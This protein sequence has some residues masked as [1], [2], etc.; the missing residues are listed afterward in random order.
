[1]ALEK[2]SDIFGL[3]RK[4]KK[5]EKETPS[6]IRFKD[7]LTVRILNPVLNYFQETFD[8]FSCLFLVLDETQEHIQVFLVV[9]DSDN[10]NYDLFPVQDTIFKWVVKQKKML[11]LPNLTP[12]FSGIHY[13]KR[14]EDIRSL[15][16]CPV[17]VDD[18]VH[19]VICVD[20]LHGGGMPSDFLDLIELLSENIS[21][22]LER[23]IETEDAHRQAE[24]MGGFYKVSQ[25]F[26]S[27]IEPEDLFKISV[28][29]AQAVTDC[30]L[31]YLIIYKP[32]Q[33]RFEVVASTD[34]EDPAV[35][36]RFNYEDV[37]VLSSSTKG[38]PGKAVRIPDLRGRQRRV[39]LFPRKLRIPDFVA[40]YTLPLW[41][42]EEYLGVIVILNRSP[43]FLTERE[44][45]VL[46]VMANQAA[47]SFKN[48]FQF[49]KVRRHSV[50]DQLLEIY[51]HGYF[52]QMLEREVERARR[53]RD[54]VSVMIIDLDLF[55][56]I[57]DTYGHP[58][59]DMVLKETAKRVE[60][61]L[62]KTDFLARYGGDE[63]VAILPKAGQQE[64]GKLAE[65]IRERVSETPF[66]SGDTN[67]KFTVS[68]GVA[69]FPD[70][71]HYKPLLIKRADE[72]MYQAKNGGRN[73]VVLSQ[74]RP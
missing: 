11:H 27:T 12:D 45:Q 68:V 28:T 56:E 54:I 62:R 21:Y 24:I 39:P 31:A 73:R 53:Y 23:Y 37:L 64:A 5:L 72:A 58:A 50:I 47:I 69:T 16:A 65:R 3:V 40:L 46:S 63:L 4:Q 43:L 35:G 14:K 38:P 30:D 29:S 48:A 44:M 22:T 1:M 33:E 71:A 36:Q 67:I 2:F 51:N 19:A 70:N 10:V 9:P 55:K 13:Y 59:G 20:S 18:R 57:N 41:V 7:N 8:F 66:I 52:Q 42:G 32:D 26:N 74:S 34:G 60:A 49:E 6:A 25:K 61:T 17:I 15:A